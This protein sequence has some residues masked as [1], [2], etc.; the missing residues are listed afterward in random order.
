[1]LSWKSHSFNCGT[2][3]LSNSFPP[4]SQSDGVCK[5]QPL[6]VA[7]RKNQHQNKPGWGKG[8]YDTWFL[9]STYI[10]CCAD[11]FYCLWT[12]TSAKWNSSLSLMLFLKCILKSG[13][14]YWEIHIKFPV[15]TKWKEVDFFPCSFL[16]IIFCLLY[17][18]AFTHSVSTISRH[19][20]VAHLDNAA[21][22]SRNCALDRCGNEWRFGCSS[23]AG[24]GPSSRQTHWRAWRF[25]GR[26]CPPLSPAPPPA[27]SHLAPIKGKIMTY[28]HIRKNMIHLCALALAH[29]VL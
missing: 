26:P 3:I 4:P 20:T 28:H 23:C 27:H 16:Y 15:C 22:Q 10:G 19:N 18:L 7:V 2:N 24:Q 14:K 25:L 29:L 12:T 6:Y 1:M 17:C 8:V 21:Q 5:W 13:Q 9:R 11:V